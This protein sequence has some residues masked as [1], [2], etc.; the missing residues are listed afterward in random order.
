MGWRDIFGVNK[1]FNN[2]GESKINSDYA[3][4]KAIPFAVL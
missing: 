2:L 3:D 1:N 4:L